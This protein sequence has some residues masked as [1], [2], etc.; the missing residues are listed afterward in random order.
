MPKLAALLL[1][2]FSVVAA[3]ETHSVYQWQ[4]GGMTYFADRPGSTAAKKMTV[5]PASGY[6]R[7][8]DTQPDPTAAPAAS[9]DQQKERGIYCQRAKDD[10]ARYEGADRL[11]RLNEKGEKQELS[12]EEQKKAVENARKQVELWCREKKPGANP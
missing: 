7:V 12:P 3:A 1:L 8:E 11:Y 6:P 4:E 9:P 5:K 2:C 10:L